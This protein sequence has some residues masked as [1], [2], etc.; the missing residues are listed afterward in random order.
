MSASNRAR[1]GAHVSVAGGFYL[2]V[3]RTLELH[4]NACQIFVKSARQWRAKPIEPEQVTL[5]RD[6]AE[7]AD[8]ASYT[9]AHASYLINLASPDAATQEKSSAALIDELERCALLG[10]PYLVLHPG[11]HVGDGEEIGLRR[12]SEGLREVLKKTAKSCVGV[13]ILLENTAGQGTNLGHDV[14]HL[15]TIISA[16]EAERLG[17][18]IDTCHAL[19]AGW[20]IRTPTGYKAAMEALDAAVG[21]D[22]VM[23]FHLNDS[24]HDLGS[25]KDRHE[26]IGEGHV[27]VEG[28][29]PLLKDRRFRGRPMLLETPKK[30]AQDD[31]RNLDALRQL[32]PKSAR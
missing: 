8:L 16:V 12:I 24:K 4:A 7:A 21:L 17:V 23:A 30:D 26:H 32:L 27:G 5:F 19:A 31:L 25:R 15:G 6:A 9:V 18:C 14:T 2:G 29:A 3:E 10:V 11:S 22:R 20:E 13:K 1:I 28:F